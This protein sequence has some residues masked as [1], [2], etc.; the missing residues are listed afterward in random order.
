MPKLAEAIGVTTM[1]GPFTVMLPI[2]THV[3]MS[4]SRV[5][6]TSEDDQPGANFI[7]LAGNPSGNVR[8]ELVKLLIPN[9]PL[10]RAATLQIP[11]RINIDEKGNIVVSALHPESNEVLSANGGPVSVAD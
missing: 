2:G 1:E 3:P 4:Y 11:I 8:R 10:A 6:S 7:L 5:F 9:L